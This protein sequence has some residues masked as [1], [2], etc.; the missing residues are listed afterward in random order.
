MRADLVIFILLSSFGNLTRDKAKA[1]L[2]P[3]NETVG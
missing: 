3:E 1:K 2:D